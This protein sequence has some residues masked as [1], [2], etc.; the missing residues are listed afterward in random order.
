[1]LI[2]TNLCLL[3]GSICGGYLEQGLKIIYFDIGISKVFRNSISLLLKLA[4]I[5]VE[6]GVSN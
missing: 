4:Q 3:D 1:M 5:V 6:V 2:N